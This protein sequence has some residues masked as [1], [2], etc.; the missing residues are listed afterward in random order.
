MGL[1]SGLWGRIGL[2]VINSFTRGFWR[3]GLASLVS[4]FLLFG[5]IGV[6]CFSERIWGRR[7]RSVLVLIRL[8]VGGACYLRTK[9]VD[10]EDSKEFRLCVLVLA[11]LSAILF[12][13]SNWFA[14]FFLFERR[15]L[16]IG[17][18]IL[19]WGYQPE[20]LQAAGY[21]VMYTVSASLPLLIALAWIFIEGGNVSFFRDFRLRVESKVWGEF[22]LFVILG[23]FLVKSPVFIV[24]GWLP[25]AHVEA[26]VSGSIILAGVL[27]KF[28]GY[29]C[30][31]VYYFYAPISL[32]VTCFLMRLV[33]WG[34]LFCG[35]MCFRQVD[36]K[37]LIAYSSIG[38]MAL[39][40][41]G[42]ITCYRIG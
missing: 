30:V 31:L 3:L 40:L 2:S 10:L 34:G 9:L 26:P 25:K 35:F 24:H 29:G 28:G 4:R 39:C 27:L 7:V 15:L 17:M 6:E 32:G 33:L 14:L 12:M 19:G 22:L 41:G 13:V 5:N 16:P 11:T 18:L 1:L 20:R 42:F 37:S 21:M 23:A 38:H 8:W 36:I